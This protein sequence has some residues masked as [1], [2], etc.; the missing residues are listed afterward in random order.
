MSRQTVLLVVQLFILSVSVKETIA[1][2]FIECTASNCI[3]P[4]VF[5]RTTVDCVEETHTRTDDCRWPSGMNSRM[6]E[7]VYKGRIAAYKIQWNSG[8]WSDWFVPGMNDLDSKINP[9]EKPE[10]SLPY[11][12]NSMRKAWAYFIGHT[13]KIIICR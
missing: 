9:A 8:T 1:N 2:G 3:T 13:H 11:L 6:D 7:I 4:F 5:S 12:A 10:C